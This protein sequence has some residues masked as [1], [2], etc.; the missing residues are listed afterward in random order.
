MEIKVLGTGCPKCLTLEK[1]VRDLVSA[2][3]I[4][5]TVMKVTDIVEIMG[6]GVMATPGLVIDGKVVVKGRVPSL[7]E[8]NE[9]IS[10]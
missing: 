1:L 8:L 6:Y 4:D 9:L 3:E 5:A 7:K 10:Q 2:K